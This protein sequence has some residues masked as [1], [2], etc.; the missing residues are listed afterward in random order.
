MGYWILIAFLALI[1]SPYIY[2]FARGKSDIYLQDLKDVFSVVLL[3]AGII[4]WGIIDNTAVKTYRHVV[5]WSVVLSILSGYE[6]S[7]S[8]W[9]FRNNYK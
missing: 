5:L 9:N 8:L 4:L 7:G 6:F 1:L 3:L 2:D